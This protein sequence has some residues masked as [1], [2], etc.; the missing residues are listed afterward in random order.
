MS[1]ECGCD[2]DVLALVELGS[3]EVAVSETKKN[4]A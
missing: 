1:D 2:G 4:T 3:S